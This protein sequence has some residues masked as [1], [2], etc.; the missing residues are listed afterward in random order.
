MTTD[1]DPIAEQYQRS[2]Q[3]PWRTYI[4]AFGLMQL[5][6]DARGK[7][8]LDVACGEGFYTR[9]LRQQGA[10]RAVGIDLSAGMI[11]LAR[12]QEAQHAL[13]IEY[14]VGDARALQQ[15]GQFD[16]AVAAYLLNYARDRNEL[17]AMCAGIADC[18][19]PGGRFVTVNSSPALDFSTAPSCR[20][21]GFETKAVSAWC[22]GTP[23][24]WTF[25]LDGSSFE[26]EN[27]F[28]DV[29]IHED[30]LSAAGFREV[31]WHAPRVSPEGLAAFESGFWSDFLNH[32]PIALIE[33]VK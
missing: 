27:Y 2:K 6:G 7:A 9:M 29:A 11:E 5:V 31:R 26:I 18:L 10:A 21:Y 25:Y 32:S 8:V 19:R 33:C 14:L 22:E 20:K 12:K 15:T 17:S 1:Y 4:E 13:G 28:L 23:V 3:Q 24:T 16:L 30:C